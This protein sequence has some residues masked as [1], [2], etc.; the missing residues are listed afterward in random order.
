[1]FNTYTVTFA[2]HREIRNLSE[3]ENK[4][5]KIID[6][7]MH[8][9]NY[10]E[11]LVGNQGEFDILASRVVK[12]LQKRIGKERCVLVLVLPYITK[13][14]IDNK[15]NYD[16]YYD[17]IE[18]CFDAASAYP[19]TAIQIRNR[20]M[21]NRADLMICWVDHKSGGAYSTFRYAKSLGK[22]IINIYENI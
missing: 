9:Y 13:G 20:E 16:N 7:I 3:I 6:D 10:I 21:V 18:L 15:E 14:Y 12:R 11:F 19:K 8:N 1:M 22:R 17:E 2:G 5:E 4:F